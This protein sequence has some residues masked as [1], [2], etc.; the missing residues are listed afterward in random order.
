LNDTT[1]AALPKSIAGYEVITHF[2]PI[3]S[4]KSKSVVGVESLARGLSVSRENA[5][6]EV[7]PPDCLFAAAQQ[8]GLAEKL[9]VI[10]RKRAIATF[11]QTIAGPESR[12]LFLNVNL[13]LSNRGDDATQLMATA[14]KWSIPTSTIVVEVLES[15]FENTQE[16]ASLLT[17]FRK[18]GF[19]IALDD[20]GA[21]H[22]NL[23][24]VPLIR[25]DILKVDRALL[26]NIDSD[27]YK[28][29]TFRSL[30]YL[31]RKIGA[32]V[33]AE[34][35]ETEN[36]AIVAQELGA[37][38]LQGFYLAKPQSPEL[39]RLEQTETAVQTFAKTFKAYMV[40]KINSKKLQ[41]LE[42]NVL[43]STVLC[44][45]SKVATADF[46]DVLTRIVQDFTAIECMY[47]LDENGIQVSK[48]VSHR[49]PQRQRNN[50][51]FHPAPQGADH[52]L[53]EYYYLLLDAELQKYTTDP[54]VSMAS[55]NLCRTISMAFRDACNHQMHVLCIDV[56]A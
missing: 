26:R 41:H 38:L 52:S 25:P 21:G 42:Y 50:A 9:E 13:A 34:G 27:Y 54:Y 17:Q 40:E 48:T 4:V 46:D 35:V 37:D 2:Q 16:L 18:C 39:L 53:K 43:L 47:I 49:K 14:Q 10:C 55:G 45:I 1:C 15:F 32:L 7:V 56:Q 11:A 28:Q 31:G 19:L 33:V 24:R 22:S 12:L 29:G 36:E 5:S 3:C 51:L 8:E 20:V 30:V 23:D 44:E 6:R